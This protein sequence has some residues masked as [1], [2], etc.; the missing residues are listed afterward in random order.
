MNIITNA[1]EAMPGG[2]DL[3]IQAREEPGEW[4]QRRK[5]SRGE[6]PKI[7]DSAV[8]VEI[9]DRGLGIHSD[10]L[11]DIFKP[12]FTTKG[13]QGGTGHGLTSC[14]T[15]MELHGGQVYAMN[16]DDGPGAT[17]VLVFPAVKGSL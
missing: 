11:N 7:C 14:K 15:I 12:G 10:I 8:V 5:G 6:P 16:N 1:K 9:K 13:E 4:L 17:F 3:V 2:G